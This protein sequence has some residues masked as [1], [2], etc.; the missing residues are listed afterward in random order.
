MKILF[1]NKKLHLLA[2]VFWCLFPILLLSQNP[3]DI[4]NRDTTPE[5]EQESSESDTGNPFDINQSTKKT[6]RY[7]PNTPKEIKQIVN[8]E[9]PSLS[10][11]WRIGILLFSIFSFV[12][13]RSINQKGFLDIFKSLSSTVKLTEYK[14]SV[15]S[16]F[17]IQLG[18]FYLF[19]IGNLAYFIYLLLLQRNI[20]LPF[21]VGNTFFTLFLLILAIYFVKYIVLLIIEYGLSIRRVIGNH[22]FSISIH[23]IALGCMLFF[24]NIFLAFSNQG[25]FGF[26]MWFGIS[27]IV[28]FYLARQVKGAFLMSELR[29]FNI[30]HFFIYLCSCEISPLLIGMKFITG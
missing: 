28:I 27:L 21:Q 16:L 13:F 1:D 6:Q 15:N 11:A 7:Q 4:K 17:N 18:L 2:I 23:N 30:F 29:H 19:F 8:D 26:F 10:R 20:Q 9:K 22:L 24:I 14:N 12:L 25:L 5:I 3:F